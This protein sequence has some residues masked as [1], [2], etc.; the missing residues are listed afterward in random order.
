[1]GAGL[2]VVL[3]AQ[4][5]VTIPIA[6]AIALIGLGATCTLIANRHGGLL[7]ALNY[8]VYV[9]LVALALAAEINLRYDV[10]TMGDAALAITLIVMATPRLALDSRAW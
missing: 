10:L 6:A 7:L 2:A 9:S 4:L 8:A 1:M 3:A 5:W